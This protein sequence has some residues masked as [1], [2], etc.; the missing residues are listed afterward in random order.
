MTA[1][2]ELGQE[3]IDDGVAVISDDAQDVESR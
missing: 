3:F 2:D 1:D